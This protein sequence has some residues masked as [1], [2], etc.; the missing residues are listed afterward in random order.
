MFL[1]VGWGGG[2]C[3]FE[4]E[5]NMV[6]L[7]YWSIPKMMFRITASGSGINHTQIYWLVEELLIA[8]GCSKRRK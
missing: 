8:E 5:R 2:V 1:G 6:E 7:F 4:M 3:V